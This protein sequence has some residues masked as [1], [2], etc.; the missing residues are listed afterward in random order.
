MK[1]GA[2]TCPVEIGP[3]PFFLVWTLQSLMTHNQQVSIHNLY[4]LGLIPIIKKAN[5]SCKIIYR[6]HIEIRTDLLQDPTSQQSL[7]WNYLWNKF[8]SQANVFVAHPVANFVP[9]VV[10]VEKRYMLPACTD[11]LDGINKHLSH[12]EMDYY[13]KLFNRIS[14]DQTGKRCSFWGRPYI[15]QI[16]RFDPSKGIPDVIR[17]Y[18]LVRETLDKVL[19]VSQIPQLIIAGHGSVDDPDGGVIYEEILSMI[20]EEEFSHI[21]GD[22]IVT[23]VPPCDQILNTLTR[24]AH[25]ALQLSVREGN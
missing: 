18:A 1:I 11:P 8:I 7:V 23:R 10:P 2:S 24:G 9:D 5:P 25:V 17:A 19:P 3:T 12:R 4:S 6:S 15:V 21:S 16:S 22:I 14:F 13:R 20:D